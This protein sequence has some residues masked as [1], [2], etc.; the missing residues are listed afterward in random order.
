[1]PEQNL[2]IRGDDVIDGT[3]A[4]NLRADVRVRAGRIVVWGSTSLPGL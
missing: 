3:G 1:M 4:P 2:L